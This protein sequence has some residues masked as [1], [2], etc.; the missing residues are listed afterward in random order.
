MALADGLADIVHNKRYITL[1]FSALPNLPQTIDVPHR[2]K[3]MLGRLTSP[4][5]WM[6][7]RIIPG[8][9]ICLNIGL[10]VIPVQ[11]S[12]RCLLNHILNV[13]A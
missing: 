7:M 12:D 3:D 13:K 6:G 2:I 9:G 8:L 4:P 5:R 11:A 1:K 10:P